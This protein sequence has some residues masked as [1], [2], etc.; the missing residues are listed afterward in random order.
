[1]GWKEQSK[2]EFPWSKTNGNKGRGRNSYKQCW[3]PAMYVCET[4]SIR[5]IFLAP[6]FPS[7]QYVFMYMCFHYTTYLSDGYGLLFH[8]FVYGRFIPSS[9]M[10]KQHTPWSAS[11]TSN[12]LQTT[13]CT[14]STLALEIIVKSYLVFAALDKLFCNKVHNYPSVIS[15]VRGSL[16]TAAVNPTPE[17]PL[18]VA[19]WPVVKCV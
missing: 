8:H 16:I 4:M 9:I 6:K 12:Q 10:S 3:L 7:I 5:Q 17:L 18:P 1:M 15:D 19:Y 14:W 13:T 2:L 11:T